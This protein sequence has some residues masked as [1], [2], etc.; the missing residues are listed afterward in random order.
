MTLKKKLGMGVMSAALGLSLVGGGTFAYFND[1]AETNNTFAAG[2][3]DLSVDPVEIVNVG[4]L[5]PGDTIFRPFEIRNDGSLDIDDVFL[6]T[7]YKVT[8]AK[9]D[10]AG[11]DFGE[12]IR[13]NFLYN[14]DKD[15]VPVFSKTLKELKE[16]YSNGKDT[17]VVIFWDEFWDELFNGYL[18]AGTQ[19][20]LYVEF[21][22]VDNG[23]EQNVFQG[24]S[25]ELKWSFTATQF[26]GEER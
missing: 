19:D 21:E 22:F 25:L 2:T 4:N 20:N 9:G 26:E 5:K 7:D 23:Q 16:E 14:A 10:N 24:D 13:V 11:A 17:N 3:L 6:A 12:H 1:T 15:S 8:D 18:A